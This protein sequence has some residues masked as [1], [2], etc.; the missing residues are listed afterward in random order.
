MADGVTKQVKITCPGCGQHLDVSELKPFEIVP[1]VSC[2]EKLLVPMQLGNYRLLSTI[3]GGGMGMVYRAVDTSLGRQVAVKLLRKDLSDSK[4]FVD[5]FTREARAV[6]S[7]NHPNIATLYSFGVED[8]Q[9]YLVMELVPR[10]SLDDMINKRRRIPEVEALDIGIQIASGLRHAYQRGLIHRDIKPGNILFSDAGVPKIVDFGLAEFHTETKKVEKEGIWGTPYYISP[11]KVAGEKEDFRSDIY[12]LGGTLFHALAGRAPFEANTATDVVV[13]HLTTPALSLKTF[14]P[15][16]T[17]ETCRAVGRM[18]VKNRQARYNSYDQLIQE[19]QLAKQHRAT[20]GVHRVSQDV[21]QQVQKSNLQAAFIIG[22]VV[23]AIGVCAYLLWTQ[24]HQIFGDQPVASTT[25]TS[26]PVQRGG[27][28]PPPSQPA[29]PPPPPWKTPLAS[30]I[31]GLNSGNYSAAIFQYNETIKRMDELN[32]M[33]PWMQAQ[34]ALCHML[35]F[36]TN[37]AF[38]AYAALIPSNAPPV[39]IEGEASADRLPR[40]IAAVGTGRVP[41]KDLLSKLDTMPDWSKAIVQFHLGA[42]S[43]S[44]EEFTM[45]QKLFSDYDATP[46]P[47]EPDWRWVKSFETRARTLALECENFNRDLPTVLGYQKDRDFDSA[48]NRLQA[49][50][51]S[52]TYPTLVAKVQTLQAEMQKQVA[53]IAAEKQQA[54]QL[55]QKE[56]LE[57]DKELIAR[58]DATVPPYMAA[59]VFSPIATAYK[60][61]LE[62]MQTEEGKKDAQQRLDRYQPLADLKAFAVAAINQKPWTGGSVST[63]TGGEIKGTL[64]KAD[65]D[66]LYFKIAYGEIPQ[67]WRNLAPAQ[68][69]RIFQVCIAGVTDADQKAKLEAGLGTFREELKVN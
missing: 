62:K 69:A 16:V 23:L 24:R 30:A 45:A 34:I 10:G 6:A 9:Y 19:L 31:S 52:V 32:P 59:Y 14:A 40:W 43:L 26:I 15:D 55:R 25:A 18:L 1:C 17:E 22:G 57:K 38:D 63:R 50:R 46:P 39:L 42:I 47:D 44:R 13:K 7:L 20:R 64:Y 37:N 28:T 3:G 5:T 29:E 21:Q 11:E 36:Q 51:N 68:V 2:G 12:S 65:E 27:A 48:L 56:M 61:A 67:Q 8:G 53:L 58:I 41:T 33:R 60:S 54:E 66:K 49:I 4:A 35:A